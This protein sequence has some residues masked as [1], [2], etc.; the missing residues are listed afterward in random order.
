MSALP[1]AHSNT[2]LVTQAQMYV[3]NQGWA[4]MLLTVLSFLSYLI[5]CH[6]TLLPLRPPAEGL[7]N[8]SAF[9]FCGCSSL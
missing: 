2:S 9:N 7:K 3:T 4:E 6:L 1:T 8:E 5:T